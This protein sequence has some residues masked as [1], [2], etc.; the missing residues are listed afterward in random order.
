MLRILAN[1]QTGFFL[2]KTRFT[3]ATR[4]KYTEILKLFLLGISAL[5]FVETLKFP[6]YGFGSQAL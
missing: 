5:E 1:I 3:V 2:N 4:Q 6:T